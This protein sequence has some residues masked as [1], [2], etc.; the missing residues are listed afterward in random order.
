MLLVMK[1]ILI[2]GISGQDGI[3]LTSKILSEEKEINII[4]ISRQNKNHVYEKLH[5]LNIDES[6]FGKVNVLNINLE[7]FN[8]I[9]HLIQDF[10]FYS[11]Y[12][13]SG[14][15]SINKSFSNKYNINAIENI[16]DNL[17]NSLIKNHNFCNFFQASSSE[18]FSSNNL[19]NLNEDSKLE[20][21]SPYA[22][23]K[24]KNHKKVLRLKNKYNWNITSGILFNHES[25][26][27]SSEFLIKKIIKSVIS[28]NKK[29]QD[30]L[31]VGTLDYIRDWSH[32][33]DICNGIYLVTNNSK[34]SHYVIGSGEGNSIRDVVDFCFSYF[35]MD[36]EKYIQID[37]NLLRK[38][39]PEKIIA[40]NTKITKDFNWKAS[41]SFKDM[42]ESIINYELK[43]G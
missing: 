6:M 36:Y 31:T 15:S 41:I 33:R 20:P 14:P 24:Y 25:E 23:A 27:R 39:D 3:F 1:N 10:N 30:F 16:F 2:S 9:N 19:K 7:N 37:K 11:V 40:D 35:G 5:Y 38:G 22:I 34:G 17:T 29:Q 21:R 26:F 12:N 13:L 32:A 18:M 4:G 43:F 42:L 8:E 28:I